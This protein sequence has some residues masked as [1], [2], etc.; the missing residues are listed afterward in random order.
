[1]TSSN[2]F[3]LLALVRTITDAGRK[4][5]V[6]SVIDECCDDNVFNLMLKQLINDLYILETSKN[7]KDSVNLEHVL[8]LYKK[9]YD[10]IK[11][12]KS[13]LSVK[14]FANILSKLSFNFNQFFLWQDRLIKFYKWKSNKNT[15]IY[16]SLTTMLLHKPVLIISIPL[17]YL[18]YYYLFNKK[19]DDDECN[20]KKQET[21]K[22]KYIDVDLE[23]N[24]IYFIEFI[25]NL[26]DLQNMLDYITQ[27]SEKIESFLT[28]REQASKSLVMVVVY[29]IFVLYFG[30]SKL[31]IIQLW[32][33][34]LRK[35]LFIITAVEQKP[36]GKKK[37]LFTADLINDIVNK[38]EYMKVYEIQK[39]I[40]LNDTQQWVVDVY[41]TNLKIDSKKSG[42]PKQSLTVKGYK[43]LDNI[44]PGD[45]YRFKPNSKWIIERN[46]W[47]LNDKLDLKTSVFT[48]T[49]TSSKLD[50][51]KEYVY[52]KDTNYRIKQLSRK[53]IINKE[54]HQDRFC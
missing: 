42:Y 33:Y 47:A 41:T 31:F 44:K 24:V 21:L 14:E 23:P 53:V 1:M 45:I 29:L 30:C 52:L 51:L 32:F 27:C 6:D 37:K 26:T 13:D 54:P 40:H 19:K 20:N 50:S 5:L 12:E 4:S 8:H 28:N 15:L 16:L 18:I 2:V 35:K 22:K 17:V 36:L 3:I 9:I 38:E 39:L 34:F 11:N 46:D 49:Y 48:F 7:G 10:P 43:N 25:F